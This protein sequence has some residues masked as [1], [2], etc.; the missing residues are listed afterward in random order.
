MINRNHAP[1]DADDDTTSPNSLIDYKLKRKID[2]RSTIKLKKTVTDIDAVYENSSQD[3]MNT[4]PHETNAVTASDMENNKSVRKLLDGQEYPVAKGDIIKKGLDRKAAVEWCVAYLH[5][6][7]QLPVCPM[8]TGERITMCNW[9]KILSIDN[10]A[11]LASEKFMVDFRG[12]HFNAKNTLYINFRS[13]LQFFVS[14]C[15]AQLMVD[16]T[17]DAMYF[18]HLYVLLK[19][20]IFQWRTYK[21][22][23]YSN[24]PFKMF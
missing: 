12:M 16:G 5:G 9:L 11:M 20:I 7:Y 10:N 3:T 8:Y 18:Q 23:L 22:A 19:I 21:V 6:L 2:P 17:A 1:D 14:K 13:M 24:T 4:T 15:Q